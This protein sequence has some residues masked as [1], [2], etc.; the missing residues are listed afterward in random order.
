MFIFEEN[1]E[2]T[3]KGAEVRSS[4][5]VYLIQRFFFLPKYNC[6]LI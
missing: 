6:A 5:V 1:G 4:F 2:L 3:R